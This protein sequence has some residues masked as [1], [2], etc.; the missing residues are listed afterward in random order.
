MTPLLHS[1]GTDAEGTTPGILGTKACT[2]AVPACVGCGKP[3]QKQSTPIHHTQDEFLTP[4][5]FASSEIRSVSALVLNHPS[6]QI[7]LLTAFHRL[8]KLCLQAD[9]GT[10]KCLAQVLE[11]KKQSLPTV[12]FFVQHSTCFNA[13]CSGRVVIKMAVSGTSRLFLRIVHTWAWRRT[14]T[15]AWASLPWWL[16]VQ[17]ILLR[18][19]Y[20]NLV[21]EFG[22]IASTWWGIR[23][24]SEP[25]V[26][27]ESCWGPSCESCC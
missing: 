21:A 26:G 7:C 27:R 25:C 2:C 3:I 8:D 4:A 15:S 12:R 5:S 17:V 20:L 19:V 23:S 16:A 18:F 10:A 11:L 14:G 24:P 9:L 13:W 22:G 6:V 1:L